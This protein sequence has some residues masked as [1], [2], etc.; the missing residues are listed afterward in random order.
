MKV[1]TGLGVPDKVTVNDALVHT[2]TVEEYVLELHPEAER[3]S[4]TD[5]EGESVAVLDNEFVEVEHNETVPEGEIVGDEQVEGEAVGVKVG[6]KVTVFVL[7]AVVEGQSEAEADPVGEMEVVGVRLCVAVEQRV[8]ENVVEALDE[9][10]PE[11]LT[12]GESVTLW[13]TVASEDIV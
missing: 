13:E 6:L 5:A 8:G 12:V 3:D 10:H 11:V 9:R 7:K 4:E 1:L 2:V